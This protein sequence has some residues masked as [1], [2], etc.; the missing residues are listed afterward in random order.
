MKNIDAGSGEA[1][2]F[3][4]SLVRI[5]GSFDGVRQAIERVV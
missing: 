3:M 1:G 2:R 4:L 5:K